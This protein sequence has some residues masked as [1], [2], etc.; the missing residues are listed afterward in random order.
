MIEGRKDIE[1]KY[2]LTEDEFEDYIIDRKLNSY[3]E[4]K[5]RIDGYINIEYSILDKVNNR[6][7][8]NSADYS[9]DLMYSSIYLLQAYTEYNGELNSRRYIRGELASNSI[10]GYNYNDTWNTNI[11]DNYTYDKLIENENIILNIWIPENITPGDNIYEIINSTDNIVNRF[12]M[13]FIIFISS[14]ILLGAVIIIYIKRL[15]DERDKNIDRLIRKFKEYPVEYSAIVIVICLIF[16]R[17]SV[18]LRYYG[19]DYI[20]Y[21]LIFN[22]RNIVYTIF[23]LT[24]C[25]LLG[26]VIYVKYKEGTIVKDTLTVKIYNVLSKELIKGSLL[27]SMIGIII[28]YCIVTIGASFISGMIF[29]SA[30]A[31]VIIGILVTMAFIVWGILKIRYLNE[32][33]MGTKDAVNGE[34]TYRISEKGNGH[35]KELAHNINNIRD[36]LKKSIENEVKSERMKTELITNVSHDLK[37]PLTSIIN[38]IDLLKREELQ[39]EEARDYVAVLDKK[40]QR[41]KILIEDLFEASKAASGAMELNIEKIDIIQLLIQA[42]GENDEKLKERNLEIKNNANDLKVFINGDGRRLYRVFEN[43]IINISKYSMENTRVYIDIIKEDTQVKIIMKNISAYEL[44]LDVNDITE[45]FK[46]GDEARST[47][48]SGL[49]LAITKSIVELHKGILNIEVDGDL[50]KAILIFNL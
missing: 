39:P 15:K 42:L 11:I 44:N 46:R 21:L 19:N 32:I 40:S 28:V 14:I 6:V 10:E 5:D 4:L 7:I 33:I 38:Y 43:L 31:A 34:L 3:L 30:E 22:I 25:C 16:W 45:R 27:R 50:F 35:L 18:H 9:D 48:G 8:L 2:T 37:T 24:V 20:N 17:E 49:G 29:G 41:L 1:G 36:G 13:I 23:I 47:E 12:H 26:V